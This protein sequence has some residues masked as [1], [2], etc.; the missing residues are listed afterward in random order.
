MV[1]RHEPGRH[2]RPPDRVLADGEEVEPGGAGLSAIRGVD[3]GAL[4]PRAATVRWRIA[5]D[6]DKLYQE[7][8]DLAQWQQA[9]V[10]LP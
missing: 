8:T 9:V 1:G 4:H 3:L 6:V 10:T 5:V 2:R 7:D